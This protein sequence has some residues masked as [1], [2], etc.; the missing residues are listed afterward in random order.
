MDQFKFADRIIA[1]N[2]RSELDTLLRIITNLLRYSDIDK[3]SNIYQNLLNSGELKL[4]ENGMITSGLQN[5]EETY[6]YLNRMEN[7]HLEVIMEHFSL[8][9]M[10]NID[11]SLNTAIHPEVLYSFRFRNIFWMTKMLM[12]EKDIVAEQQGK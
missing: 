8:E 4:L 5:L 11:L 12:E 3:S 2:D 6:I 7:I 1:A 9:I 10:N